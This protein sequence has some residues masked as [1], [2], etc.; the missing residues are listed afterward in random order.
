MWKENVLCDAVCTKWKKKPYKKS[1][2][3]LILTK[4]AT[5]MPIAKRKVVRLMLVL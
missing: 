4:K 2:T 1:E 5:T 3:W